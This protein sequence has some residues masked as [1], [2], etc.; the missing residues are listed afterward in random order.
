MYAPAPADRVKG[1]RPRDRRSDA[2]HMLE[3]VAAGG[4]GSDAVL[5][6]E[7]L[8]HRQLPVTLNYDMPDAWCPVNV[9]SRHSQ[10]VEQPV[11]LVLNQTTIGQ[12]AALILQGV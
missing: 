7:A 4:D 3:F 1:S 8:A 9:V 11:G 12:A 2:G 6:I 10:P 5:A